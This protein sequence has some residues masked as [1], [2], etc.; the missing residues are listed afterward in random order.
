MEALHRLQGHREQ[1]EV[2]PAVH[3]TKEGHRRLGKP[4]AVV[5]FWA[6]SGPAHCGRLR[7]GG[8]RR[9]QNES[10]QHEKSAANAKIPRTRC[11]IRTSRHVSPHQCV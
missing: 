1:K 10:P 4:A 5:G 3:R 7:C 8:R 11:P 2:R 6:S 9:R